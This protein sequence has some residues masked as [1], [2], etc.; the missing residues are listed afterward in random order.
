MLSVFLKCV[1]KR[2]SCVSMFE[3]CLPGRVLSDGSHGTYAV[4]QAVASICPV[5]EPSDPVLILSS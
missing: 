5:T 1:H 4:P 3:G 2:M